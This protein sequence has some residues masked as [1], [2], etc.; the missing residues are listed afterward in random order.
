MQLKKGIKFSLDIA[1]YLML[2][3]LIGQH[4]T[5]AVFHEWA[6]V[7]LFIC[8]VIHNILNFKWYKSLFK[9]KYTVMRFLQ[10]GVN[11]FLIFSV[12][13]C[14]ASSLMIS[15]I[16]FKAVRL[17]NIMLGRQLHMVF[18]AWCFVLMSMH[19]GVHMRMP[20]ALIAKALFSLISLCA[21]AYGVFQFIERKF[22]EELFLLVGFKWFDYEQGL[23]GYLFG[24]ICISL[25][26][27]MLMFV[28]KQFII[29]AKEKKYEK[30][31]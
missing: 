30:S 13:G 27:A 12:L 22:Y 29:F 28:I 1:M 2:S 25:I 26:F 23:I 7:G 6:G 24:T 11:I 21:C 15:G 31:S 3:L 20:K 17:P 14:F 4:M 9:G 16:V 19:F 5:P 10:T 18:S 8:F